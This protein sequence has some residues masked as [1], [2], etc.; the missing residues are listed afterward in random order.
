[1]NKK[2]TFILIPLAA[3]MTLANGFL[4]A[5][6]SSKLAYA[7]STP[8]PTPS[9]TATPGFNLSTANRVAPDDILMEIGYYG[10]GGPGY[11]CP[12]DSYPKPEITYKYMANELVASSMLIACGWQGYESA[13]AYVFY[14]DMNRYDKR[15]LTV[16]T[17]RR[18]DK[19]GKYYLNNYYVINL[20]L[21]IL[22]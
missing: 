12:D 18:L 14:P 6:I 9:P 10:G 2:H 17:E 20:L 1:M 22:F 13:F 16:E 11:I 5:S 19:D 3:L 15:P 21:I 7:T 8:T 4:P